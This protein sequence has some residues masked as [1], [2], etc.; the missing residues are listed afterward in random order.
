MQR[1]TPIRTFL[2]RF[3][4]V[5]SRRLKLRLILVAELILGGC[6]PAPPIDDTDVQVAP[7]L[8]EDSSISGVHLPSNQDAAMPDDS[9][10]KYRSDCGMNTDCDNDAQPCSA[11]TGC[12]DGALCDDL[13]NCR[14]VMDSGTN[15]NGSV[16]I[17]MHMCDND[18]DCPDMYRCE[19]DE[20]GKRCV[21]TETSPNLS[22]P[23]QGPFQCGPSECSDRQVCSPAAVAACTQRDCYGGSG[24]FCENN[25]ECAGTF[26]CAQQ[27]QQ[28]VGCLTS[29]QCDSPNVCLNSGQCGQVIDRSG[30]NFTMADDLGDLLELTAQCVRQAYDGSCGAFASMATHFGE[31]DIRATGCAFISGNEMT[32]ADA[33]LETLNGFLS[34]ESDRPVPLVNDLRHHRAQ[35]SL[36]V[37]RLSGWIWLH[38]CE[39]QYVPLNAN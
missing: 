19:D 20:S 28:C 12:P 22:P 25:C 38:A 30:E 14:D 13:Q 16:C 11:E 24:A 10:V 33:D 29:L 36:C 3:L 7:T 23:D 35:D 27:R 34:C 18:Q 21:L 4:L 17:Q 32:L 39:P 37:T 15:C 9:M 26:I 31:Q 2:K 6:A 5:F 8:L 1:T